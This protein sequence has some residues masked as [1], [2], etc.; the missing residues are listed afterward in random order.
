MMSSS[1]SKPG[2]ALD[3]SSDSNALKDLAAAS[4]SGGSGGGQAG[5]GGIQ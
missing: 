4:Y 1:S 3:R 5:G 2:S